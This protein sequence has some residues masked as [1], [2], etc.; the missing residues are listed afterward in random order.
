M[1]LPV[2]GNSNVGAMSGAYQV[3]EFFALASAKKKAAYTAIGVQRITIFLN[4]VVEG[5]VSCH[6]LHAVKI[7]SMFV[8]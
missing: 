5:V 8:P 1:W 2:Q 7:L 4:V 6:I 3:Y